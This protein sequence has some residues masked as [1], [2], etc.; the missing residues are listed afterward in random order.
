MAL[1]KQALNKVAREFQTYH[2][3]EY[4]L[5]KYSRPE[6]N[7]LKKTNA[8]APGN[9]A[10]LLNKLLYFS[11]KIKPEWVKVYNDNEENKDQVRALSSSIVRDFFL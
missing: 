11:E 4:F 5:D 7:A 1:N 10:K 6:L 3:N 2:R 9:S 8:I